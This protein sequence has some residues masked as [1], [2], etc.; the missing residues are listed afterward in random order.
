MASRHD[1]IEQAERNERL[2]R[3]LQADRNDWTDWQI[4]AMFYAALHY[5]DAYLI[6]R[7]LPEPRSHAAQAS[8]IAND[9]FLRAEVGLPFTALKDVSRDARYNITSLPN[10]SYVYATQFLPVRRA[11]RR[12]LNLED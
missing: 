12:A 2:Y 4:T 8:A 10:A 6:D 3:L 1:H 9:S 7:G 11:I 5:V